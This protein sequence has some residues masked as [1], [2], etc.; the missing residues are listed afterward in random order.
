[1]ALVPC[2]FGMA[3]ERREKDGLKLSKVR[4]WLLLRGGKAHL[5][6]E[7]FEALR[8]CMLAITRLRRPSDSKT[9]I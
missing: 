7:A 8:A 1:M 3:A 9:V 4:G 5:V 2:L 6:V